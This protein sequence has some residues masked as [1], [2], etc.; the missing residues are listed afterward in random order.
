MFLAKHLHHLRCFLDTAVWRGSDHAR[1]GCWASQGIGMGPYPTS[2]MGWDRAILLLDLSYICG[3]GQ[4][5]SMMTVVFL[6]FYPID[7]QQEQFFFFAVLR[8]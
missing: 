7:R 6:F 3:F 4:S 1:L 5:C 2:R 8:T